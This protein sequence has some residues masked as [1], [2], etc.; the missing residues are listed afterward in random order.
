MLN[1]VSKTGYSDKTWET[2]EQED[3]ERLFRAIIEYP[4][5]KDINK[6]DIPSIK[7][8]CHTDKAVSSKKYLFTAGQMLDHMGDWWEKPIK[9]LFLVPEKR[10][11][12][13]IRKKILK[14][15][16]KKYWDWTAEILKGCGLF[17]TIVS[18]CADMF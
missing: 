6:K 17:G 15:D 2:S 10:Q 13:A 4:A 18:S 1:H 14:E 3:L 9:L 5:Y 16:L 7:Q 8:T 12:D 11:K